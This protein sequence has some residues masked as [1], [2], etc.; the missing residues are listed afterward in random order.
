MKLNCGVPRSV[1]WLLK[2]GWHTWYAWHPVRVGDNDCRWL[3][4]VHRRLVSLPDYDTKWEYEAISN[5]D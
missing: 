2:F 1:K 3:E 5:D 4:N